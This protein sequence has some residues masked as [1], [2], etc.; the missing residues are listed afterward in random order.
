MKDRLK[1][2]LDGKRVA[3]STSFKPW[4]YNLRTNQSLKIGFGQHDYFNGKMRAV[5]LYNRALS[6]VEVARVKDARP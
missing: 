5:R 6:S 3:Q 2:Y 1:I 4:Q